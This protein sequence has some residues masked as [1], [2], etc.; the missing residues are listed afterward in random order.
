[1]IDNRSLLM[2]RLAEIMPKK[3]EPPQDEKLM[4]RIEMHPIR[5]SAESFT[6]W[7][8]DQLP[9]N[10]EE[11]TALLCVF[12]EILNGKM[13]RMLNVSNRLRE[14]LLATLPIAPTMIHL[15]EVGEV[16]A[17]QMKAMAEA[18]KNPTLKFDHCSTEISSPRSING[19]VEFMRN[20]DDPVIKEHQMDCPKY[21]P[22]SFMPYYTDAEWQ[23][24]CDSLTC[25]CALS[26]E[27]V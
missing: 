14:D 23:K 4:M 26:K 10:K 7:L 20:G 11:M 9:A 2:K 12:G 22:R 19:L 13:E 18:P 3:P 8:D 27:K 17:D 6:H 25:T 1:M 5:Q 16:T 21:A 24:H 15:S